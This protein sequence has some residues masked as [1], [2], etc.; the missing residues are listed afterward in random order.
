MIQTRH[1]PLSTLWKSKEELLLLT[2]LFLNSLLGLVYFQSISNL[3]FTFIFFTYIT[4]VLYFNKIKQDTSK[5]LKYS[6]K[7]FAIYLYCWIAYW[8][9][10]SVLGIDWTDQ[11]ARSL[12]GSAQAAI[13]P[14]IGIYLL[15]HQTNLR[16]SSSQTFKFWL[17]LTLSLLASFL[18]D[19]RVLYLTLIVLIFIILFQYRSLRIFTFVG[20]SFM[21]VAI[22]SSILGN[23]GLLSGSNSTGWFLN[24][25]SNSQRYLEL[26]NNPRNSDA[27]RSIQISCAT[28]I[29]LKESPLKNEVFGYGQNQHKKIMVQCTP[30][31]DRLI[32]RPVGFAAYLIDFGLFG[33]FGFL[34]VFAKRVIEI[35]RSTLKEK[36]FFVL[37]LA[38][39]TGWSL[40]TNYLDN[41]VLFL[42]FFSP[43]F[44]IFGRDMNQFKLSEQVS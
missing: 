34:L 27:D 33:L 36:I 21:A 11:Q 3:R 14:F 13:V 9:T 18:F 37:M 16:E 22:F 12:S 1:F 23:L 31:I 35:M 30:D 15:A 20:A 7:V 42:L 38:I 6:L 39:L 17:N 32:V 5:V 28:R 29:I 2:F 4:L 8:L 43:Y 40:I 24:Q 44:L 19:S 10:L 25:T 26:L 41:S